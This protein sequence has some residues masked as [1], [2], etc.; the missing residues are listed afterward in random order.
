MYSVNLLNCTEFKAG[1][2]TILR[3]ILHPDKQPLS[4]SYSLAF[5]KVEVG[6]TSFKHSLLSSEVYFILEG[7][8]EMMIDGHKQAVNSSDTVY[9]PPKSVQCIKN[10]GNRDLVFLCIVDP[11]WKLQDE[12]VLEQ[13]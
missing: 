8:G 5:A 2:N 3:E 13:E 11:A 4:I 6:K 7:E 10:T 1:D 12:I 9:I